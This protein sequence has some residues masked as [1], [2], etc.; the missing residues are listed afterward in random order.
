[1][2][3]P[4]RGR[5]PDAVVVLAFAAVP[6]LSS[7]AFLDQYTTVKWYAV[8]ALAAAWLLAELWVA[9]SRGWPAF[10]RAH[11]WPVAAVAALAAWSALRAGPALA[12]SPLADR[13][14][15]AVLV[16]CAA[17]HFAR[18]RGSTAAVVAGT[19]VSAALT[20]ALGLVQAAGVR[21]PAALTAREGPAA[22]FGN[23]NMA[24][25]FVGLALVLVLGTPPWGARRGWDAFRLA[26]AAG[27]AAYLYVL[28]SRSVLLA[29]VAAALALSLRGRRRRALAA[30]VAAAVLLALVWIDPGARLD[31][32]LPERK[33]TSI[34]LRLA[35]WADTLRLV[36]DHP[37]GVGAG[38]FEHAFLP[39]QVRAAPQETIVYRSPHDEYL[40]FLAE[41]GALFCAAA[42]W[43]LVLLAR[44][45]RASAPS[46]E[47]RTLVVGWTAFLAAESVFQFPL[48]LAMGALAACV[49]LGAALADTGAPPSHARRA[50][51]L[52]LGTIA[53]AALAFASARVAVSESLYVRNPDDLASLDRACRLDPRN[54]PA[55]VTAAWL[56]AKAGHD[57]AARSRLDAALESTPGYP[58]AVKLLGDIAFARGEHA[59]A[60][61]RL[62][63][64][65]ALFRGAS[66][67]HDRAAAAC[68]AAR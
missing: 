17:W 19:A 33:E 11:P 28:S 58:P 37:L 39:Y 54:L 38:R 13:A 2:S 31:R 26:L 25:Q 53:A 7:A 64:Y 6:L 14:A 30:A 65:D 50:P 4:A 20:I 60:C 5:F 59:E 49:T 9:G 1:M 63:E 51:W 52:A 27:G 43:A 62:S 23:V 24:A 45:W 35:V 46:P 18:N 55:C 12:W 10:V 34:R 22:L 67:S 42:A 29:L 3:A 66:A 44:R 61:R 36:R 40:R 8:H 15:C 48:A 41:D 68:G 47:L 21:L 16:L 32:S 56:E 57:E